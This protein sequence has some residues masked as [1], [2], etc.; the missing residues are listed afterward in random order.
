MTRCGISKCNKCG[1]RLDLCIS[2]RT[3]INEQFVA[4]CDCG[5]EYRLVDY[6]APDEEPLYDYEMENDDLI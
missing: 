3:M 1:K 4:D 5:G 2:N 6:V